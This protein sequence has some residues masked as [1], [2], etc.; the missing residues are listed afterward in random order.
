M[1]NE[2]DSSVLDANPVDDCRERVIT[3]FRAVWGNNY[4][5]AEAETGIPAAK[6]KRLC[7]RVQQPTIEMIE[8]LAKTRPYFLLWMMT[9][10]AQT[11]FQL[12]PHD[13]W[14]DKLARAMGV[15]VDERHKLKSEQT[16]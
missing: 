8:A 9:G 2:I 7:I 16:P 5:N 10:H 15:D 12:S 13:R 4:K 11:Y 3:V 14:Q 1:N 6:W